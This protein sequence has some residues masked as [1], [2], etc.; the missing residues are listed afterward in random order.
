VLIIFRYLVVII[1]PLAF[2]ALC[3]ERTESA[4]F[5]SVKP[6]PDILAF[7][8]IVYRAFPFLFRGL[9]LGLKPNAHFYSSCEGPQ[10]D[11]ISSILMSCGKRSLIRTV[12][13]KKHMM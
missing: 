4:I 11:T 10:V 2:N 7:R 1:V 8:V 5:N 13:N 3:T 12:E 9:E 6:S